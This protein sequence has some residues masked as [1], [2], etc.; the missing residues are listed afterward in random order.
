M[1]SNL[2]PPLFAATTTSARHINSLLKCCGFDSKACI[3]IT[4]DGL[5]VTVEDC[6]VMQAHA[7][8][9]KALFNSYTFNLPSP[10]PSSSSPDP[11]ESHEE[12]EPI[13]FA[14]SLTALLECL[15]IFGAEA[16][17]DKW[18]SGG[19]GTMAGGVFDQQV[20]RIGGSCK[21][22]YE[23]VGSPL[24]ITL[25]DAG[26]ITTCTLST[27]APTLV[28]DIP[29]IRDSLTLKIIMKS[30]WLFDAI[31]ELS[32]TSVEKLQILASPSAPY[33]SLSA[34]GPLGSTVVEFA[35]DRSLLETFVV[36]E[37]VQYRYRFGL[38]KHAVK[39]MAVS[40]KVSIRGDRR[41]T[42]SLQFMVE[43]DGGAPSFIDFRFLAY[44]ADSSD[45][46]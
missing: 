9:D 38:I 36:P 44:A 3:Q 8:I 31:T 30:T 18:G 35:N 7:F 46:E 42:L 34:S 14:V 40:S 27:W 20:L 23:A 32:S 10:S 26:V 5:R 16:G 6:N 21:F 45:E 41:G 37:T 33:F 39:A 4:S 12:E 11:G 29:I 1:P 15:Q 25:D 17:R 13:L 24:V 28:D 19:G 22:E 43:Q 2:P